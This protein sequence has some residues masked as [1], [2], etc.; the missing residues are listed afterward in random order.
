MMDG[1][2]RAIGE[3]DLAVWRAM[4]T[5]NGDEAIELP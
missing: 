1:S 2:V 4:G 5:R 3:V